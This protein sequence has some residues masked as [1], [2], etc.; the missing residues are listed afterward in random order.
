MIMLNLVNRI[1]LMETDL[2]TSDHL[3]GSAL[4]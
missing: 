3:A 4:G 2:L 1:F